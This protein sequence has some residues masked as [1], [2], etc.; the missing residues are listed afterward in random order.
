MILRCRTIVVESHTR[1]PSLNDMKLDL[2]SFKYS[3][4]DLEA[5]LLGNHTTSTKSEENEIKTNF[6]LS[7]FIYVNMSPY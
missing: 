1:R 6:P 3:L 4:Q 5:D 7:R 2:L